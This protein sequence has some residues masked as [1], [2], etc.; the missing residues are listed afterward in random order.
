MRSHH[1]IHGQ[2]KTA[3]HLP[4]ELEGSAMSHLVV[5][6]LAA[7]RY[8][9]VCYNGSDVTRTR[10]LVHQGITVLLNSPE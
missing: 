9:P 2:P 8:G 4:A 6:G 3:V 5:S 7:Y 1:C 10:L